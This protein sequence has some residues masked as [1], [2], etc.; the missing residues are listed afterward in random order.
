M[1]RSCS[2][3]FFLKRLR[4]GYKQAEPKIKRRRT[5]CGVSVWGRGGS[6]NLC[7]KSYD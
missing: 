3:A 7:G 1:S 2:G 4:V 5:T 6:L